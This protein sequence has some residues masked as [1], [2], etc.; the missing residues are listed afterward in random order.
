MFTARNQCVYPYTFV[1]AVYNPN[2]DPV[3]LKRND[4]VSLNATVE[5]IAVLPLITTVQQPPNNCSLAALTISGNPGTTNTATVCITTITAS[6]GPIG[7]CNTF[8]EP[9]GGCT[10]DGCPSDTDPS[11]FCIMN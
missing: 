5:G 3:L 2:P 1:V 8:T 4:Y 10:A 6:D 7:K 11:S 9:S